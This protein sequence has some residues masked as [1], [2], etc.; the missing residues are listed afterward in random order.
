MRVKIPRSGSIILVFDAIFWFV[1][2]PG[3]LHDGSNKNEIYILSL[4]KS[5]SNAAFVVDIDIWVD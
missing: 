2:E 1:M 3:R 4:F 5:G